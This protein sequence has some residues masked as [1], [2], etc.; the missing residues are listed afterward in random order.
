MH[1]Q[2]SGVWAW[3]SRDGER[4]PFSGE[5]KTDIIVAIAKS[6]PLALARLPECPPEFE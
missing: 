5:T 6:E 4:L 1:A 2:T 3:F